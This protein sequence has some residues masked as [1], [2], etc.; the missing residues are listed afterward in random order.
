MRVARNVP[1]I[2]ERRTRLCLDGTA[3]VGLCGTRVSDFCTDTAVLA[4]AFDTGCPANPSSGSN[5]YSIARDRSCAH[6]F[7]NSACTAEA[8][9]RHCISDSG[10][11]S[12]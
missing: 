9:K 1:N 12:L 11:E 7:V 3:T 10:G 6:G 2:E 4:N 8:I 5:E